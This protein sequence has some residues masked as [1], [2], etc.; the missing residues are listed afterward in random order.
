MGGE[1]RKGTYQES[2]PSK[3]SLQPCLYA[4]HN[5]RH[6]ECPYVYVLYIHTHTTFIYI[7]TYTQPS[8]DHT[9][10]RVLF[11]LCLFCP[12]FLLQWHKSAGTALKDKPSTRWYTENNAMLGHTIHKHNT[13]RKLS[14]ASRVGQRTEA[15]VSHCDHPDSETLRH[16]RPKD[17]NT[18][19]NLRKKP[20]NSV[21]LKSSNY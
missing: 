20:I 16:R 21:H 18:N 19:S 15:T 8:E 1:T 3:R 6:R 17:R 12:S 5:S 9:A 14:R 7:H 10:T 11:V 13:T 2:P 4:A